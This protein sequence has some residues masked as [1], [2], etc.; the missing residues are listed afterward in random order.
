MMFPKIKPQEDLS[1]VIR[2]GK[3][4]NRLLKIHGKQK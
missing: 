3:G 1:I 2:F 4:L